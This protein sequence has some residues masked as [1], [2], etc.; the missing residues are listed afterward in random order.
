[1]IKYLR[2]VAREFKNIQWPTTHTTTIL[3]AGVIAVSAAAIIY[4][5]ALDFVFVA[6]VNKFLI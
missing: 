1:M 4:L 2:S 5:G 6:I 3:T